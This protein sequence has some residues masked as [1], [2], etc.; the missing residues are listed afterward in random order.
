M[1]NQYFLLS[2][3]NKYNIGNKKVR[4]FEK[5]DCPCVQQGIIFLQTS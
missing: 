4:I 1:I 3:Y 2:S 5:L